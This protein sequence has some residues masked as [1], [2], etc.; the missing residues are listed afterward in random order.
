MRPIRFSGADRAWAVRYA[1]LGSTIPVLIA[2]ATDFGSHHPLFFAGAAGACVAP[3]VVTAASRQHRIVFWAA[4]LGGIPALT[5]MQSYTGGVASGYS[6]LAMMAMV[7]FG[8]QASDRELLAG[9]LVLALCCFLPMLLIGAPAYPVSWGHAGLLLLIGCTVAGSLRT[10]TRQTESLTVRLR[11]EAVVDDLTGLLNRRGWRYSA[12]RELSRSSRSGT[13]VTLV[14]FDLDGLKRI[15]DQ[16]G[17]DR[18]DRVLQDIADGLRE[19]FRAGD[20]VARLGG[21]EFVALLSNTTLAGALSAVSRLRHATA[22]RVAFS[23]GVALWD[24]HEDLAE[25][26]NRA[27]LALYSAKA[28][29]GSGTDTAPAPITTVP[30]SASEAPR[31]RDER[32]AELR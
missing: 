5:A 24:E 22:T 10:V 31:V 13:P 7:W 2:T 26:L 14:M 4:A 29:G 23:A 19:T 27:D 11:Q 3:L 30:A 21:D 17:H 16:E 6:V 28:K 15:N 20:I 18:G 1:L 25:V 12:P 32:V 8:L 9:M